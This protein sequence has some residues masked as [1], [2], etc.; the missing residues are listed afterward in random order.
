MNKFVSNLIKLSLA[1]KGVNP[2]DR[3]ENL[4]NNIQKAN[5]WLEANR[6]RGDNEMKINPLFSLFSGICLPFSREKEDKHSSNM[7]KKKN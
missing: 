1:L 2:K 5:K 3:K 4:R 6:K 7:V